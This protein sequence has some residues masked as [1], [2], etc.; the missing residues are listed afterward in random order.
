[1][2]RLTSIIIKACV[3]LFAGGTVYGQAKVPKQT[4]TDWSKCCL[5]KTGA[6][7]DTG[8]SQVNLRGWHVSSDG[9]VLWTVGSNGLIL[10]STDGGFT[11]TRKAIETKQNL[12]AVF[13]AAD[14]GTVWVSALIDQ[15][16]RRTGTLYQ[17]TDAGEHWVPVPDMSV[18][19]DYLAGTPDG[20]HLWAISTYIRA[21][22]HDIFSRYGQR[23][24]HL[25]DGALMSKTESPVDFDEFR[26]GIAASDDGALLSGF[27]HDKG[28]GGTSVL[29][30]RDGSKTWRSQVLIDSLKLRLDIEGGNSATA[31]P[32][33]QRIAVTSTVNSHLGKRLDQDKNCAS[34]K[35]NPSS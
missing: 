27:G 13:A 21:G 25:V 17:S 8:Y 34:G 12:T 9:K 10:Q 5:T 11:W 16:N 19:I 3:I 35:L 7:R 18:P 26:H 14:G 29:S 33:G 28:R 4:P 6:W 15:P 31:T 30:S 24:F 22:D 2:K 20:K 1:M 32:D 23:F